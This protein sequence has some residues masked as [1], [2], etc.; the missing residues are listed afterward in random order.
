M[1]EEVK[2]V[3]TVLWSIANQLRGKMD[4]D[5][6]KDYILGF[7]FFKYISSNIIHAYDLNFKPTIQKEFIDLDVNS[8]EDSEYLEFIK[9]EF[10]NT[11]GYFIYPEQTFE[12]IS[13][14]AKND[15]FIIEN[16][17]KAFRQ[18]ENSSI[19][20]ASED[21]FKGLFESIDLES[22][23]LG[24]NLSDRQSV[25]SN[26]I[27]T[28]NTI[29]LEVG[30]S[31]KDILGDAYEYML[32]N[33]AAGAGKKGGEF[34]TPQSVAKILSKIVTTNK[35]KLKSVYDP[36]CGS[37]SLLLRVAKEVSDVSD[38]FG[39]ELNSTTYNLARMNLMMHGVRFDRF[40]IKNDDTL[41][42]P[43]HIDN[44]KFSA[45]VA[46]PPFSLNWTPDPTAL[47]DDR[48]APFGVLAPKSK[49]D[50][51]FVQH[52]VHHLADDGIAAIVLPHGVLFRGS[53]ELTIRKHLIE[54]MNIL[55]A[56][57]GLPSNIFYG[58]SI[59]TC[60]LV[61]KK[62]REND[63]ILFIDGSNL[64]EK[65]K[66]QNIL[67]DEHIET[68]VKTYR[69]RSDIDKFSRK[70]SKTEV[71]ENEYNLNIP[72][73]IDTFEQEALID[74]DSIHERLNNI[75]SKIRENDLILDRFCKELGVL[76]PFIR[77]VSVEAGA[78]E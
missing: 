51:A 48:F 10:V 13:I 35:T 37:G 66:N 65:N 5:E 74:L 43:Q 54:K 44:E 32:A 30:Y 21:D 53:S 64:F 14:M 76:P 58:T 67:N 25:V 39:Q 38:F 69:E 34:Y 59:P 3:K 19:N 63:D 29:D 33:F 31:D 75:E 46:N 57:I 78:N 56:V 55:D 23:K 73:Y 62:C 41:K 8:S 26:I 50:F 2:D 36:T 16:I 4:A 70:V 27:K 61:F 72:R 15:E 49:A 68:I 52:I 47:N 71:Y 6:F 77:A 60:I 1:A 42:Y 18:I 9:A 28:L 12:K 20:T 11:L 7:I 40:D 17:Q 22:Q 45:I 24:K